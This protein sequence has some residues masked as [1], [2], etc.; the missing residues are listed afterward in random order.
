MKEEIDSPIESKTSMN[1]SKPVQSTPTAVKNASVI[2]KPATAVIINK[3]TAS[4]APMPKKENV[5]P[6]LPNTIKPQKP[7]AKN[8]VTA[9]IS[10]NSNLIKKN[11]KKETEVLPA[12]KPKV[13]RK[14]ITAPKPDHV[15]SNSQKPAS[16][17]ASTPEKIVKNIKKEPSKAVKISSNTDMISKNIKKEQSEEVTAEKKV[18][19]AKITAPPPDPR[20]IPVV[21]TKCCRFWPQCKFGDRCIHLHQKSSRPVPLLSV[22][23]ALPPTK[24]TLKDKFKWTASASK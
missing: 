17:I 15:E 22:N 18:V 1:M 13:I 8:I 5:K 7:A 19:R 20:P 23:S 9:K 21:T 10:S 16:K 14:K 3:P 12:Q 2:K 6:S 4:I 24:N 11:I